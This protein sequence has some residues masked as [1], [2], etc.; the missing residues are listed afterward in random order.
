MR[1]STTRNRLSRSMTAATV[2]SGFQTMP[3]HNAGA[4]LRGCDRSACL[5]R[6]RIAALASAPRRAQLW[7]FAPARLPD[8]VEFLQ[9]LASDRW[10]VKASDA[11]GAVGVQ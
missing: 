11:F 7:G 10:I 3:Q 8:G 2:T 5:R 6:E 1:S 4:S 9:V